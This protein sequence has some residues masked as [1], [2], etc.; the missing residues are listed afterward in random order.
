MEYA[1]KKSQEE[2]GGPWLFGELGLIY[3]SSKKNL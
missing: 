2:G 3:R 1:K